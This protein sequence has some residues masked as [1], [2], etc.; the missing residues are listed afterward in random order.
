MNRS[1]WGIGDLLR[2]PSV[3]NN[4]TLPGTAR[5]AVTESV[6]VQTRLRLLCEIFY[7]AFGSELFTPVNSYQRLPSNFAYSR[8]AFFAWCMFSTFVAS[9]LKMRVG[10]EVRT[11]EQHP[12]ELAWYCTSWSTGGQ[13]Y[14][15]TNTSMLQNIPPM[16][17]CWMEQ[18][19]ER[20]YDPDSY[21][22]LRMLL[23]SSLY[24]R[25]FQHICIFF[26]Y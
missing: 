5:L 14:D 6:I 26:K 7:G 2:D 17:W 20:R 1:G 18:K 12:W 19:E 25:H 21:S 24:N 23:P 8:W 11:P 10:N 15:T 22:V 13:I 9:Q 4:L 3:T 16:S